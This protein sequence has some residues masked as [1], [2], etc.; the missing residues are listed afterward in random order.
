MKKFL[1]LFLLVL[2]TGIA[3]SQVVGAE[4]TYRCL[5]ANGTYE[6]TLV[7]YRDCNSNTICAGTNCASLGGCAKLVDV[8]GGDPAYINTKFYTISLF[9][10][11]VRDVIMSPNCEIKTIC[12]NLGCVTPGKFN[13]GYER[14][15]F[16]G[17]INIG[18]S[19]AVPSN[20]CA[21]RFTYNECCR[22]PNM[23]SFN[24]NNSNYYTDALVNRCVATYPNCNSAKFTND[25]NFTISSG[26]VYNFNHGAI[27]ADQDSLV[28][29]FTPSL[30]AYNSSVAYTPPYDYMLPMNYSSGLPIYP[31]GMNCNPIN[32][33]FYFKP[34]S[35]PFLGSIAI[36][37]DQYRKINN[38]PVLVGII[39]RDFPL[40]IISSSNNKAPTLVT[41]P[42]GIPTSSPKTSFEICAGSTLCFT[43]TAKDTDY[44]TDTT[45]LSWN[46]ALEKYGATFTPNYTA[47]RDT[48][49]P[50][51]DSYTF[52]WTPPDSVANRSNDQPFTFTITAE[53][54]HCPYVGFI[55]KA[56]SIKVY[57]RASVTMQKKMMDCNKWELS[58]IKNFTVPT[59][60]FHSVRWRIANQPNDFTFANGFKTY[61]NVQNTPIVHFNS[62]GKYLVEL[63]I[64]MPSNGICSKTFYDTVEVVQ[65]LPISTT[66]DTTFCSLGNTLSVKVLQTDTAIDNYKWYVLPDTNNVLVT[67]TQFNATPNKG[68]S[69]LLR[70]TDTETGCTF[71]DTT[72]I[73]VAAIKPNFSINNNNQCFKGNQF[74]F[75]NQ[76]VDTSNN[77][78][79]YIWLFSNGDTSQSATSVTK[80]FNSIGNYVAKLKVSTLFGCV[81]SISKTFAVN[82][83]PIAKFTITSDSIQCLKGN[84]FTYANQSTAGSD[85][86]SHFWILGN[87]NTSILTNPP[88]S[89]YLTSGNHYVKLITTTLSNAC[90]DSITDTI[91]INPTPSVNYTINNNTQCLKGNIYT[92]LNQ[93]SISSGSISQLW[94]F[95]DGNGT[96]FSSPSY[97]F[98]SSGP[99]QVK[100]KITS[101]LGC[102]D[103]MI[104]NV[105]VLPS[106]IADFTVQ[107]SVQ[108]LGIPFVFTNQTKLTSGTYT[109]KWDLDDGTLINS[110]DLVANFPYAGTFL[111]QLKIVTDRFCKDSFTKEVV[112][113]EKPNLPEITGD[114]LAIRHST[115]VYST[116]QNTGSVYHWIITGDSSHSTNNHI[117]TVNWGPSAGGTV[118][119]S[120]SNTLGCNSDTTK[121]NVRVIPKTG[122]SE[123]NT[124]NELV[125]YPQPAF[126]KLFLS[127]DI[128]NI[129]EAQLL[130]MEGKI[131]VKFNKNEIDSRELHFAGLNSGV[132]FLK[133]VDKKQTERIIKI[134]VVR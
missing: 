120:E 47:N 113:L 65:A 2:L 109:S 119:V 31:N 112:V 34:S 1:L 132:Y 72:R 62:A 100:L 14:Y 54:N 92:F 101:N 45:Y 53:D 80:S 87:G 16:K 114:T 32:G 7:Y 41:L 121:I 46:H 5:D 60:T 107:D 38:N 25:P 36:R 110:E 76:S 20:C 59:Q 134:S 64:D 127:G 79:N 44:L 115:K 95:G 85:A 29:S 43:V 75:T 11:S 102:M 26:P 66:K 37:V 125:V 4:I 84:S 18:P 68:T 9:A 106:P 70:A 104:K 69:Y 98:G 61:L 35:F 57:Q 89:S 13:I 99:F 52:C 77:P 49:G 111:V 131:L 50:R 58:Y 116:I 126:E 83:S 39:R 22:N 128:T 23:Q 74:I 93:S 21:I 3:K 17:T 56:F 28:Y 15:E 71:S 94:T 129:S 78:L 97:V 124:L 6:V 96:T 10:T 88:A 73:N 105:E 19:S 27:D 123:N 81:D 108:C 48:F 86:L 117:A 118:S 63:V 40:N 30:N 91:K 51:E 24:A 8:Y 42:A 103:S 82:I 67:L 12:D 55:T 130:S 33:D 122:L 133:V 90:Q